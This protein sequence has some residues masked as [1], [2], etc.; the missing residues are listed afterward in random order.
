[1]QV[2]VEID[3]ETLRCHRIQEVV[4]AEGPFHLLL[5]ANRCALSPGS[6]FHSTSGELIESPESVA[7]SIKLPSAQ[8]IFQQKTAQ[9]TTD[10]VSTIETVRVCLHL[11][12]TASIKTSCRAKTGEGLWWQALTSACDIMF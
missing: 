3:A 1:M 6:A 11:G 5:L 2:N 10:A 7:C 8:P 4:H 9:V 12:A